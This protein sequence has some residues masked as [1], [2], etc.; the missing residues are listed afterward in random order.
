[1]IEAGIIDP[2]KVVR[3]AHETAISVASVLLL[4]E[5]TVTKVPEISGSTR[6]VRA[7]WSYC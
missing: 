7:D 1:L 4:T 6:F 2:A 5:T 3:L